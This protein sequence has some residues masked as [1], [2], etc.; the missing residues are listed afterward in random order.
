[1]NSDRIS[2]TYRLSIIDNHAIMILLLAVQLR[3]AIP[4]TH[5]LLEAPRGSTTHCQLPLVPCPSARTSYSQAWGDSFFQGLFRGFRVLRLPTLPIPSRLFVV[6]LRGAPT[7]DV[8]RSVYP[9]RPQLLLIQLRGYSPFQFQRFYLQWLRSLFVF[10]YSILSTRT[11]FSSPSSSSLMGPFPFSY[12]LFCRWVIFSS[13]AF[14]SLMSASR[15]RP[16]LKIARVSI[17]VSKSC[18]INV[19]F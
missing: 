7:H 4:L 17:N 3:G 6:Q 12:S 18:S 10:R 1:M 5:L 13:N 11:P 8:H 14:S 2:H 15:E 19:R 9:R 16:F